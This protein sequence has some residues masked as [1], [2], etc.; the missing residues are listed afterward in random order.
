[1]AQTKTYS[2]SGMHCEH[3][4]AAVRDELD[5]VAGVQDVVVDLDTKLVTVTGTDL[6]DPS[7]R[8][9][10]AEAGYDSEQVTS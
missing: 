10:I 7:L 1:M 2:V 6:D 3:C 8:A 9:A 5:R 4:T